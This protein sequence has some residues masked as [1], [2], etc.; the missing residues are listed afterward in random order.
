MSEED[1]KVPEAQEH[2]STAVRADEGATRV[3]ENGTPAQ[4]HESRG[5]EL[6]SETLG[7]TSRSGARGNPPQGETKVTMK[8]NMDKSIQQWFE[9]VYDDSCVLHDAIG[10]LA[11]TG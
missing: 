6:S 8:P 4:L 3:S 10:A 9:V 1:Y 5:I 2:S 7:G 11:H